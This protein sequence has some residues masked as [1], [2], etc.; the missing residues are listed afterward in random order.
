VDIS[1]LVQPLMR[2]TRAQGG[3]LP[4]IEGK[5]TAAPFA[6]NEADIRC[7]NQAHHDRSALPNGGKPLDLT[8]ISADPVP[9]Q[10]GHEAN[11]LPARPLA[12]HSMKSRRSPRATSVAHASRPRVCVIGFCALRLERIRPIL[13]LAGH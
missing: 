11:G 12:H 6:T 7:Q 3:R 9:A 1:Y 10:D 4:V 5:Q 2:A 13:W 8:A